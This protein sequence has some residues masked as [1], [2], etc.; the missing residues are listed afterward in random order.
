M[1]NQLESTFLA[2]RASGQKALLP[3]ITAGYPDLDATI[4]ILRGVHHPAVA[5]VELGIPFSDP[6]ADG[7][8]IQTSF[9]RALDRGFRV[10]TLFE[11][12]RAARGTIRPPLVAMVSYSIVFR[13]GVDA[14]IDAAAAAG[15]CGLI[16]PDLS[17]EEAGLVSSACS[18]RG[19]G[20]VMIAAPTSS[21]TRRRLIA[22]LSAPFI[23]Y[24]SVAGVTGE[25]SGVSSQLAASIGELRGLSDKPICVGFGISQ[26][27]HVREV[28]ALA[29]GA[30]VGSAIVRRMNAVVERGG[31]SDAVAAETLHAIDELAAGVPVAGTHSA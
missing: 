3:Y 12:L 27:Q 15:I 31:D 4:S 28:C 19:V 9:S 1:T 23:Y 18:A 25:R 7:P 6:I 24:Q 29:D 22:E 21:P 11:R 16:I 2:F 20:L 10:E 13:R 26:A 17:L 8:V 5:C 14:F 30:I